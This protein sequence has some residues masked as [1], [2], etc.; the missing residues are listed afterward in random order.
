MW[1][2]FRATAYEE[3]GLDSTYSVT[4]S[5]FS[6]QCFLK[7]SRCE[8]DYVRCKEINDMVNS[9]VRG[10]C[11]FNTKRLV[12]ANFEENILGFKPNEP[13]TRLIYAD[14]TSLYR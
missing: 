2:N 13:P 3:Y 5:S 11:S 10:G 1:E 6:F 9:R 14:I 8:I 12:T 4:C 7:T